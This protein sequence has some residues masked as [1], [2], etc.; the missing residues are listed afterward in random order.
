MVKT[1]RLASNRGELHIVSTCCNVASW[2]IAETGNVIILCA[3]GMPQDKLDCLLMH[4]CRLAHSSY[5]LEK[6]M[7]GFVLARSLVVVEVY[8]A[9]VSKSLITMIL[10]L[11]RKH[12]VDEICPCSKSSCAEYMA[13]LRIAGNTTVTVNWQLLMWTHQY[14]QLSLP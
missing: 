1:V 14:Q 3:R 2:V 12:E 10:R 9:T 13:A 4:V 7:L 11:Y 5:L 8:Q 6:Y